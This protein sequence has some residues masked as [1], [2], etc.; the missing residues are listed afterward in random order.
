M[1]FNVGLQ[2]EDVNCSFTEYG[3]LIYNVGIQK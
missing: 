2:N 3:L 1:I